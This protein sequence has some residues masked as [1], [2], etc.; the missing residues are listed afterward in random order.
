MQADI[1]PTSC[2]R[3]GLT[4]MSYE[5]FPDVPASTFAG[6]SKPQRLFALARLVGASRER[7]ERLGLSRPDWSEAL[8]WNPN[9][10]AAAW[11]DLYRS[12]SPS[13]RVSLASRPL[14][15]A[16][17]DL[18]ASAPVAS[19]A[20][21]KML[22]RQPPLTR[23]QFD[24]LAVRPSVAV[25][26]DLIDRMLTPVSGDGV[27]KVDLATKDVALALARRAGLPRMLALVASHRSLFSTEEALGVLYEAA[28]ADL[29][30]RSA[31]L[32]V[33]RMFADDADLV[34][35]VAS[36]RRTTW[37]DVRLAG[38]PAL[39]GVTDQFA[40]AGVPSGGA[41]F[42]Q[43]AYV[44]LALVN[45]PGCRLEVVERVAAA[46]ETHAG[47]S[48]SANKVLSSARRRLS[49][50]P[51]V[52]TTFDRVEDAEVIAWLAD[53]ATTGVYN[54]HPRLFDLA[55]LAENPRLPAELA[56]RVALDLTAEMVSFRILGRDRA[57]RAI[58]AA[59]D[60]ASWGESQLDRALE[61]AEPGRTVHAA[62]L[63]ELAREDFVLGPSAADVPVS[64][65]VEQ[66]EVLPFW[67][68]PSA[69]RTPLD[70][71]VEVLFS[72]GSCDAARLEAFCSLAYS[73]EP[74]Y[75]LE[76]L[77]QTALAL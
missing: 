57:R 12:A 25:A 44:L 71:A 50:R 7:F 32:W 23:S 63:F 42:A 10:S 18:V 53:R 46:A 47:S 61:A 11:D 29:R 39:R 74:D 30:S 49:R 38:H 35:R 4:L 16:Q 40:V 58:A 62:K 9:L 43:R 26:K 1:E 24:G 69:E 75:R 3:K 21:S 65:L 60:R 8:A 68:D 5:T 34:A 33:Q 73:F 14:G 64:R 51:H 41:T 19:R 28:D 31:G 17:I 52:A 56:H 6:F 13:L 76:D 67:P 22:T 48:E 45:N 54:T 36:G 59:A 37:L 2:R 27:P 66:L 15:Q 55:E 20:A 70:W 77:V 72:D